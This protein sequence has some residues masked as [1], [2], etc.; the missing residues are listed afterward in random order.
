MNRIVSQS[1]FSSQI[2]ETRSWQS[3][4][5]S[6]VVHVILIT[7]LLVVTVPAVKEIA[8]PEQHFTL[9]APV[10]EYKPKVVPRPIVRPQAPLKREMLV[11]T[12]PKP[13]IPPPV[14]KPPEPKPQLVAKAPEIKM[15]AAAP[16]GKI[17]EAKI[18]APPPPKPEI[19]TGVFNTQA[20][21]KAAPTPNNVKVGGFGDPNGARAAESQSS[22]IQMAKL[23]GFDMP[24]GETPGGGGG[25]AQ[26]GG[27]HASGFGDSN[28]VAGGTGTRGTVH[29][30]GFGSGDSGG[31]PGGTGTHGSVRSAGFGDSAATA[32]SGPVQPRPVAPTTTP[33][34]ILF[35]PKPAY[36]QEAKDLRLEG[37]V[38]VEVVFQASGGVKVLRVVHGL[39]HGLDQAAQEA[40]TQ[41]RFRPATRGGV[42]V[43]TNAT[44]YI[45]FQLT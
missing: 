39:G 25:R 19:H 21:A 45:T 7:L 24:N 29:T 31:V 43:D 6:G 37:Q 12:V 20:L 36:T 16:E 5:T 22:K 42:P 44:I 27:V 9:L 35:K 14:V 34:E 10:P 3:Y 15:P 11:K 30:G 17:P 41:V 40:A 2:A 1:L 4:L 33:V 38:S 18:Q 13:E 8:K 23:G 26:N 28:G 32:P